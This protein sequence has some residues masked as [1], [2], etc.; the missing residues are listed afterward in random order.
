MPSLPSS[1]DDLQESSGSLMPRKEQRRASPAAETRRGQLGAAPPWTCDPVWRGHVAA[2]ANFPAVKVLE[3]CAGTGAAT[4]ALQLLLGT[5]KAKLAGAWDTSADLQRV[6]DVA[7]LGGSNI[8]LGPRGDILKTPMS[9]FPDANVVVAGPPCPPSSACGKRRGREDERARPFEQ[10]INVVVELSNRGR[11]RHGHPV[12][13][14]QLDD[15]LM[16]FVLENVTGMAFQP[17]AEAS[18]LR[19]V[20]ALLKRRLGADWMVRPMEINAMHY[21]LPQN[22]PRI[23]IVGRK[24]SEYMRIPDAPAQFL[25]R[26]RPAHL[27][28]LTDNEQV[29]RLTDLQ[30]QCHNQWKALYGSAMLDPGNQ[31][32]YAFVEVGR[33]PTPRTSWGNCALGRLPP[34]DRCQ[35]LRASGPQLQV[36]ALGEGVGELSLDRNLRI[37]ERAAFQGFPSTIGHVE[38]TE[39]VGRRIFGNAM[40]VPVIGSVL[41]EELR[42]IQEAWAARQPGGAHK[43]GRAEDPQPAHGGHYVHPR[44]PPA[45]RAF[46]QTWRPPDEDLDVMPGL[47][48]AAVAR[49]REIWSHWE[50]GSPG[51]APKRQRPLELADD[52]AL[53]RRSFAQPMRP[54]SPA[55]FAAACAPLTNASAASSSATR[56]IQNCGPAPALDPSCSGMGIT[57]ATVLPSDDEP[58]MPGKSSTEGQGARGDASSDPGHPDSDSDVIFGSFV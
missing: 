6:Y 28:D 25:E 16:F 37:N 56:S 49:A 48:A 42:C 32:K 53:T 41:A 31:G 2:L 12:T 14:G 15:R 54:N 11:G 8:N 38:A 23:Y 20:C 39:R 26:V 55:S 18:E 22:R 7:H 36:F 45:T 21:G 19:I 30:Q 17:S 51:R 24:V 10:C 13:D 27:L 5:K 9:D 43:A 46:V 34:V 52:M 40:A 58:T 33:D 1:D 57:A 4:C 35:C 44:S 3:L 47:R 50:S 29:P